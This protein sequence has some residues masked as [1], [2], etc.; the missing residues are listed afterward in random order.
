MDE[1]RYRLRDFLD[2]DF[3]AQAEVSGRLYPERKLTAA[4]Y[5]RSDADLRSTP[6]VHRTFVVEERSTGTAVAFGE[7]TTDPEERD[8]AFLWVGAV[9]DPDHQGR[10]VGRFLADHLE[11]EAEKLGTAGVRANAR[12]DRPR[13]LDFLAR[14]GY[15]ER[16]RAWWSRLD[17][18]ASG[19]STLPH[20]E[21][22][23]TRDGIEF[24]T[25]AREG[26]DRTEVRERV[27]R[28]FAAVA[29]DEPR[30]GSY[31]PPTF[32]QFVTFN[33]D[34]PGFL[35]EAFFLA[36][37]GDRYIAVSNLELRPAQPGVLH[38]VLTG[39]LR[40][41]RGRGIATELKLRTVEYGQ[42]HGFRSIQT[43]ND[44]LNH[45]MW[46]INE[47]L[48]FQREVPRVHAEKL[49]SARSAP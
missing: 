9:V 1:T 30:L 45:P 43:S 3:A 20:R 12:L 39:T 2:R 23:W 4:E 11:A 14:R 5:R 36:R 28:L 47:K 29:A 18:P 21:D 7:V 35:P 15:V 27:Y 32:E 26:P 48:G 25:L 6:M 19:I 38:Q 22:R 31:T 16:R 8:S 49:W 24:T 40:E 34:T 42:A 33:L 46:A 13:D 41:F 44:S 10:G 37:Q 17:L